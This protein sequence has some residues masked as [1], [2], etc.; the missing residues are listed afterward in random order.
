MLG[1]VDCIGDRDPNGSEC[2]RLVRTDNIN[3]DGRGAQGGVRTVVPTVGWDTWH[4]DLR[5]SFR[6]SGYIAS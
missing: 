5:T 2:S 3:P 6:P 4:R 1:W